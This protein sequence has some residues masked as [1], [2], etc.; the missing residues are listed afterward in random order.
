[1]KETEIRRN[2]NNAFKS[3]ER[4]T[5]LS[6]AIGWGFSDQDLAVI[7]VLH[8]NGLHREKIYDLLEDCNFHYENGLLEEEKYD[9]YF[10]ELFK[11]D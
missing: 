9:E 2:W 8:K 11:E 5:Q 10:S 4:G 7:G 3:V 1:M 6:S